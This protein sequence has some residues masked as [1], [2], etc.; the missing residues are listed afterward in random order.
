MQGLCAAYSQTVTA[1]FSNVFLTLFLKGLLFLEFSSIGRLRCFYLSEEHKA[2]CVNGFVSEQEGVGGE[3]RGITHGTFNQGVPRSSRGWI[4]T[5][6]LNKA[7][8]NIIILG[9]L[10]FQD[11]L[12]E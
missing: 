8:E 4:T 11:S 7:P 9:A 5:A 1:G 6:I 10:P 12:H 2:L 3:Y